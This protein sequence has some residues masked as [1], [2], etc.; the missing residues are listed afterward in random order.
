MLLREAKE[1]LILHHLGVSHFLE[2]D[3]IC[4]CILFIPVHL[5]GDLH[6]TGQKDFSVFVRAATAKTEL[7][8][9]QWEV[10]WIP[11]FP[12]ECF[13]CILTASLSKVL[14]EITAVHEGAEWGGCS[15]GSQE[16]GTPRKELWK[17]SLRVL[18]ELSWIPHLWGWEWPQSS[19][20]DTSP[21]LHPLQTSGMR[22]KHRFCWLRT[23]YRAPRWDRITL[24]ELSLC[25]SQHTQVRWAQ[26]E[27]RAW[28]QGQ[29]KENAVAH[30][31]WILLQ[32]HCNC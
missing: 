11:A 29:E 3:R 23:E 14:W 17:S 27:H 21:V 6:T 15:G 1:C 16:K 20:T 8:T 4:T 26:A 18:E 2:S 12:G 32:N 13:Q 30:I 19:S 28:W 25:H 5:F 10:C 24:F 31:G 9:E 7:K 22:P